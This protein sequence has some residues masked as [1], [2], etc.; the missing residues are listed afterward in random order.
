MWG[1]KIQTQHPAAEFG[2]S[3]PPDSQFQKPITLSQPS[4]PLE[5]TNAEAIV[6]DGKS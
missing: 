3:K 2:C 6:S 4:V 1:A 5:N